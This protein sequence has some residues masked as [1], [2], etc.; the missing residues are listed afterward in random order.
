MSDA[1]TR[2]KIHFGMIYE[3]EFFRSYH[4]QF[5]R[6]YDRQFD[7]SMNLKKKIRKRTHNGRRNTRV[8]HPADTISRDRRVTRNIFIL[9]YRMR[10]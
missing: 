6:Q 9:L 10:E 4:S 5:L 2:K 1:V 3:P 8:I 7:L